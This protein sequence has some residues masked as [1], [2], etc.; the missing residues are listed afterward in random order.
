M[1]PKGPGTAILG[2]CVCGRHWARGKPPLLH[3]SQAWAGGKPHLL[4]RPQA[5]EATQATVASHA[6]RC[7]NAQSAIDICVCASQ[8]ILT[9]RDVR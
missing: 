7:G 8:S 5:W 1:V 4:P 9:W 6:V 2:M 3:M